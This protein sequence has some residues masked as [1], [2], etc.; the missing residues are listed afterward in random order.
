MQWHKFLGLGG[1]DRLS[2]VGG[3]GKRRRAAF[4]VERE[5]LQRRRFERLH[6][7]DIRGQLKQMMGEEAEFRG[8]QE[9]V[10]Q[11]VMRGQ[12]PIVQITPTG[13]GKSLTFMLLAYCTADG[14]TI[15]ITPLVALENDME[16]R[17][18]RMG[19][20]GYVWKSRGV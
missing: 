14:V 12:W 20:D 5:D 15:V 9:Q 13:G 6:R 17:C 18:I 8:L 10:I 19:I 2:I 7:T 1:S 4:N 11:L 3:L 16:Q